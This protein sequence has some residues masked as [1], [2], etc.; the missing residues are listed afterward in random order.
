[1]PSSP[2]Q[3][4]F[5]GEHEEHEAEV[6]EEEEAE[7]QV[8]VEDQESEAEEQILGADAIKRLIKEEVAKST[9]VQA[10]EVPSFGDSVARESQAHQAILEQLRPLYPQIRGFITQ[11]LKRCLSSMPLAFR[12]RMVSGLSLNQLCIIL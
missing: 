5:E 12:T 2:A 4:V 10:E 7:E 9:S 3:S 8:E 6:E 11:T 1:M